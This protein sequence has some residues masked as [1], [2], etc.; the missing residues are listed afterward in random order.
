MSPT[1]TE[2]DLAKGIHEGFW[3]SSRVVRS[4]T[5]TERNVSLHDEYRCY[6]AAWI[7]QYDEL[8]SMY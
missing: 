7:I 8:Y 4:N 5:P 2:A 3:I 6:D 1:L